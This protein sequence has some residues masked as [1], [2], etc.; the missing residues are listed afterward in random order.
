[1]PTKKFD[2]SQFTLKVPI[3]APVETVFRMWTDP[4]QIKKWFLSD[5]KMALKKGSEYEWKWILGLTEKGKILNYKK[6]EKMSFTFAGSRCDLSIK[7][8]KRGSMVILHQYHI[9]KTEN[10]KT[11]VHLNCSI[12]WTFYLTN[13]NTVLEYGIDLREKDPKYIAMGTVLY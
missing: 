4:E 3:A 1:M 7:R 2:W 11:D 13:L 6:P 12:G 10:A 5:A 8:D 9:P